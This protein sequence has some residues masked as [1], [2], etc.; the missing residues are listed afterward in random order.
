MKRENFYSVFANFC[1]L[2]ILCHF[3]AAYLCVALSLLCSARGPDKLNRVILLVTPN[4]PDQCLLHRF[5]P[6][7]TA[8]V[9]IFCSVFLFLY[10]IKNVLTKLVCYTLFSSSRGSM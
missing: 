3:A 1:P 8:A 5:Q 2:K 9:S 4:S 6:G 10:I 7:N